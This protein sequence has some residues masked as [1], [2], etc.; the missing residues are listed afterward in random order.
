MGGCSKCMR[1]FTLIMKVLAVLACL[2]IIAGYGYAVKH[3]FTAQEYVSRLGKAMSAISDVSFIALSVTIILTEVQV[4]EAF[5][6]EF[7]FIY[8]WAGRGLMQVFIGI[9]WLTEKEQIRSNMLEASAER[10]LTSTQDLLDVIAEGVG[11]GMVGVGLLYF[12]MGV[13]CMRKLADGSEEATE[14]RKELE[15][16]LLQRC[17][18]TAS[19]KHGEGE[20]DGAD[21]DEKQPPP[22]A[23]A[24]EGA[25]KGKGKAEPELPADDAVVE[26]AKGAK[27]KKSW[28]G[29]QK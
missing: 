1:V 2:G 21:A 24:D 14:R 13:T 3:T 27:E 11:Y 17:D 19:P 22:Q 4:S 12:L 5:L 25:R 26:V 23:P 20:G 9:A 6:A 29:K 16:R 18:S 10:K 28:F 8:A 7:R 15:E